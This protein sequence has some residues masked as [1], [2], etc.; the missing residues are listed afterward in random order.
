[1]HVYCAFGATFLIDTAPASES[2]IPGKRVHTLR[3]GQEACADENYPRG[4]QFGGN[5]SFAHRD[6][7]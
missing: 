2:D 6:K 5:I 7:Y 3:K 1:M 4:P